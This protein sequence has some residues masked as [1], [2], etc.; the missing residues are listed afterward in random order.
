MADNV[1]SADFLAFSAKKM[2][3]LHGA[4]A[5]CLGKLNDMQVHNKM[6]NDFVRGKR[7]SKK[8]PQKAFALGLISGEDHAHEDLHVAFAGSVGVHAVG[9]VEALKDERLALE[10]VCRWRLPRILR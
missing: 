3:D 10:R 1:I 4:I 8:K 7:G 6:A 9:G 5:T 2:Q